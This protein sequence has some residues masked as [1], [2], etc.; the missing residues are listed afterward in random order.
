M[1]VTLLIVRSG[2]CKQWFGG[3]NHGDYPRDSSQNPGS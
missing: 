3:Y 2:A 1:A